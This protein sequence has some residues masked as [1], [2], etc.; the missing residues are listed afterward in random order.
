VA[1]RGTGTESSPTPVVI[2]PAAAHE[3]SAGDDGTSVPAVLLGLLAALLLAFLLAIPAAWR[4]VAPALFGGAR[5]LNAG[6]G[7]T[8]IAASVAV[9]DPTIVPA[10]APAP[11]GPQRAPSGP[12]P[13]A[14]PSVAAGPRTAEPP[15]A[16][17]ATPGISA[18]ADAPGRADWVRAHATEAVLIAGVLAGA[19]VRAALHARR[20]P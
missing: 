5:R 15:S 16:F 6:A 4:R 19:I 3:L 18:P 8:V 2:S 10:P 20:R 12:E 9:D 7:A 14:E 13:A 1:A 11:A 17:R